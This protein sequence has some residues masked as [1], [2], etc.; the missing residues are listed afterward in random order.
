M[1]TKDK[2]RKAAVQ[3]DSSQSLWTTVVGLQ[4]R[5][6]VVVHHPAQ[7]DIRIQEHTSHHA[8]HDV[9]F[10]SPIP[11]STQQSESDSVNL[12]YS[13][14]QKP[15]PSCGGAEQLSPTIGVFCA[16]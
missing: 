15:P 1:N 10:H 9:P 4:L 6:N 3:T 2:S 16:R 7:P 14:K 13:K 11:I 8:H 12:S 5:S